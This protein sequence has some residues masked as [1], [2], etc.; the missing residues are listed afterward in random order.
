[1]RGRPRTISP[2]VIT[3]HDPGSIAA[4]AFRVLRTNLQFMGLDKPVKTILITSATPGEGKTT[5][6]INLA[7][8]FAQTGAKVLLI[9]ADLRRP[10]VAKVLGV[11]NWKGLT[12]ALLT[13]DEPEDF[14]VQTAI[15]GL[16]VLTSGPLPPNPAELVGSGRMGRLL[17]HLAERFDVV[18]VDSPPVLAVTDACVLAPKVDGAL[19]VV[20]SGKVEREKAV[21]AKEALTAV[22][23]NL[24]GVVLGDVS[25]KHG[26]GYY[27]YYSSEGQGAGGR[28]A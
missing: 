12:S 21:R 26:E 4:E 14:L 19:M 20:R 24:L 8:A 23:A 25:Q 15:P 2:M 17:E 10:T 16:S 11:E 7:I 1:M 5:T 6:A 3:H 28:R 18:L 13:Q 27:Y 9:D 22:K